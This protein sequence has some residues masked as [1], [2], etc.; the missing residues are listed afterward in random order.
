MANYLCHL[1]AVYRKIFSTFSGLSLGFL[2]AFSGLSLGFLW[3][4]SGLSLGFLWALWAFEDAAAPFSQRLHYGL[5][6]S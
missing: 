6:A 5:F 2:W 4:F 3:T 1:R